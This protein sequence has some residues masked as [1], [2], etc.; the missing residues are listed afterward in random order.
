MGRNAIIV[1][2]FILIYAILITFL[3]VGLWSVYK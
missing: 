1:L 2:N 3:I